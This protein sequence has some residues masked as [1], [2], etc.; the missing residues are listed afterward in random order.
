MSFHGTTLKMWPLGRTLP[1]SC[2]CWVSVRI[3][4]DGYV[5]WPS[6]CFLVPPLVWSW[7][8]LGRKGGLWCR[9][10]WVML[11][12]RSRSCRRLTR[13]QP[14]ACEAHSF[15]LG[16]AVW[17]LASWGGEEGTSGAGWRRTGSLCWRRGMSWEWQVSWPSEPP[18]D[19]KTAAARTRSSWIVSRDWSRVN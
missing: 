9:W 15:H 2:S 4:V 1:H 19:L 6:L 3:T 13:K 5:V 17:T 10:W 12:M 8:T 7:W 16:P 11:W 18:I 14:T